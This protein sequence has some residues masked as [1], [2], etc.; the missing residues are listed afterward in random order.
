M[1]KNISRRNRRGDR[2]TMRPEYDFSKAARGVTAARYGQGSKVVVF[3]E[4]LARFWDKH[5]LT[6]FEGELQEVREPV[7]VRAKGACPCAS[8]C[9][10]PKFS[11]SRESRAPGA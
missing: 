5:E 7:F 11:R 2:D 3:V 9:R 8:N 4:E 10:R 1:K 6:D